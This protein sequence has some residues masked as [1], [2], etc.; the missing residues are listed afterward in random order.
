MA[1]D[2]A[3]GDRVHHPPERGEVLAA[4]EVDQVVPDSVD[5]DGRGLDQ[6]VG[7]DLLEPF[8]TLQLE[9]PVDLQAQAPAGIARRVP[10]G[11]GA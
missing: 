6:Q 10:D 9:Q 4:R 2:E 1:L 11:G 3:V 7:L 8:A 5:M